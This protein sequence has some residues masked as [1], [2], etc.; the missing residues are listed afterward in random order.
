M[1]WLFQ[2][3]AS[4]QDRPYLFNNYLNILPHTSHLSSSLYNIWSSYCHLKLHVSKPSQST[5]PTHQPD[6]FWLKLQ[7]L[8][9]FLPSRVNPHICMIVVITVVDLQQQSI[10]I[11]VDETVF[12]VLLLCLCRLDRAT[13][14]AEDTL[15]LLQTYLTYAYLKWFSCQI[16]SV[17][18]TDNFEMCDSYYCD[19]GLRIT[20]Y[21]ADFFQVFLC[22]KGLV[23]NINELLRLVTGSLVVCSRLSSNSALAVMA[24]SISNTSFSQK[25]YMY[26]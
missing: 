20:V 26:S 19:R 6:W 8:H 21:S 5:I 2:R 13:I 7:V 22:C 9:F 1:V 10:C 12:V 11:V 23:N 14:Q 16:I 18:V 17:Y 3:S 25:V 24:S 15:F 4:S